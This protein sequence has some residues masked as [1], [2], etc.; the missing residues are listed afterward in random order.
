MNAL[1]DGDGRI[2]N[3]TDS[4]NDGLDDAIDPTMSPVDTD[5]D[6]TPDFRDLDSDGDSLKDLFDS[7][8]LSNA[9]DSIN[10]GILDKLLDVDIDGL[11]DVVDPDV[12]G[13]IAG[14]ILSNPDTDGDRQSNYRDTD[15]D[16]DGLGDVLELVDTN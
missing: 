16:N 4:K 9:F 7:A 13:G 10:K 5:A 12:P 15:S 1:Q 11:G 8:G 6:S 3:F 14:T 2:D